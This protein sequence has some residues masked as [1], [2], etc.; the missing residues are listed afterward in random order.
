VPSTRN[1]SIFATQ[2][3]HKSARKTR[4]SGQWRMPAGTVFFLLRAIN[5]PELDVYIG[6]GVGSIPATL[7]GCLRVKREHRWRCAWTPV[8]LKNTVKRTGQHGTTMLPS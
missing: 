5:C 6:A 1:R 2:K 3:G 8:T 4:I 7:Q